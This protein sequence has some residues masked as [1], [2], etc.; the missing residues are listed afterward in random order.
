M[1]GVLLDRFGHF[2]RKLRVLPEEDAPVFHVGAGNVHFKPGNPF[3]GG[4]DGGKLAELVRRC[5][6]KVGDDRRFVPRQAGE[7]VLEEGFHAVVLQAH[8]I[9]HPAGRFRHAGQRVAGP[10]PQG[11]PLDHDAAEMG[12]VAVGGELH[13]VAEGA[14][15]RQHRI[16]E[17][18]GFA[19]GG[20]VRGGETYGE[21]FHPKP[22]A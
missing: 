21:A 15:G 3:L 5:G 1:P 16:F 18:E 19:P 14:R 13:P 20:L 6:V 7:L 17:D 2:R 11:K 9:E 22:P 4:E 10:G 12:Q 8:G